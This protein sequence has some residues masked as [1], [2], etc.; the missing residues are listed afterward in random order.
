MIENM[1]D[2]INPKRC[3]CDNRETMSLKFMYGWRYCAFCG[4]NLEDKLKQA[5]SVKVEV[6]T[7]C[8]DCKAKRK[9]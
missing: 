8:L 5:Y 7:D 1:N 6:T 3:I 2:Q 9:K 4:A